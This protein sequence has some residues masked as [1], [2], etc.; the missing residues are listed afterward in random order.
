MISSKKERIGWYFYDWANSAFY[1]TVV[2]VF[3]GPYLTSIAES[4][5]DADGYI[6][7][8]GLPVYA[9]SYFTYI[10][11][12]SVFLQ[13]F[14][15]PYIGSVADNSG[16]KKSLLGIFAYIGS[17]STMGLYFLQDDL[18]YLGGLLFIIA[19]LSFGASVVIYNSIL[20]DISPEEERDT[21]SSVGWALGY[22]G[23][24]IVLAVNLVLFSGADSFG[25][26]TGTAIRI[27]LCSAGA[28]W[29]VFT[30]IPMLTIRRDEIIRTKKSI[31]HF[32]KGISDFILTLKDAANHPKTLTFLIAYLLY[33]DGVQTVIVVSS[34][35]GNKELG[36]GIDV[37]TQVILMV[38]FVAFGGALLFNLLASRLGTLRA[39]VIGL[40]IW[41]VVIIYAYAFLYSEIGF[42]ILGAC[43]A[44]VMGGTQA[45]SRSM[46]S[47][48]IPPGKEASYFS[49]YEI[50]ERGTSW[51]GPLLFGLALQLTHS[52]RI[53]IL[54]LIVFFVLG[55]IILLKL[56]IQKK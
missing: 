27:S 34:Q 19:N 42:F 2:T 43:I 40:F 51:L 33:N 7:F 56:R 36:L 26:E 53:A 50:S 20:N 16:R 22:L 25:I 23:G 37:L 39:I 35:F 32:K 38:Q 48:L 11:S 46:Y 44:V 10:V 55:L 21:V 41:I 5:A 12:A 28:W 29:A 14:L 49:I 31:N 18:Y 9:H 30:V 54:S 45:L 17:F 3:L 4:A 8:I 6:N 1:T 15:L 52:Y 13:I 47:K 24:G